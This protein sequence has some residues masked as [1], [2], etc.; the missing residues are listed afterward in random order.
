MEEK[1]RERSEESSQRMLDKDLSSPV[2][3][4]PTFVGDWGLKSFTFLNEE[5]RKEINQFM[6][7]KIKDYEVRF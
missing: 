7:S 3:K 4:I 1:K 5:E 6:L 2:R